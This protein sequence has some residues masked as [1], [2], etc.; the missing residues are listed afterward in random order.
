MTQGNVGFRDFMVPYSIELS[1]LVKYSLETLKKANSTRQAGRYD[2]IYALKVKYV[3]IQKALKKIILA[4][5]KCDE[6]NKASMLEKQM[7]NFTFICLVVFQYKILQTMNIVS[8]ALQSE[9][10][11]M[12]KATE[13]LGGIT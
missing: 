8:K 1:G 12:E 2:A 3:N 9:A 10:V 13:L 4:S 6:Q 11:D 7:D 5:N